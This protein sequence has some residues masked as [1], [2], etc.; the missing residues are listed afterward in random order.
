MNTNQ[1]WATVIRLTFITPQSKY[2]LE[3]TKS[4]CLDKMAEVSEIYQGDTGNSD[5]SDQTEEAALTPAM[6]LQKI[7][8]NYTSLCCHVMLYKLS[9]KW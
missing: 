6:A 4:T 5:R 3:S 8:V 7:E 2:L 1:W 9:V